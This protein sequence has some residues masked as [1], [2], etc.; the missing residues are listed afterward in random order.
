MIS[1]LPLYK[2]AYQNCHKTKKKTEWITKKAPK[3]R[4]GRWRN[5]FL[6]IIFLQQLEMNNVVSFP[7]E[8]TG[9]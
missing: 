5:M 1:K 4:G 2:A 6:L 7:G 9:K 3:I 8:C